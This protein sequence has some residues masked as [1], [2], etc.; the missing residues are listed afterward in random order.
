MRTVYVA[1]TTPPVVALIGPSTLTNECHGAFV[2][3]GATASDVCAG[4]LSV[5]TNSTINSSTVGSYTITYTATDPSG[6]SATTTRT[7]YVSDTTPPVSP[8][9]GANPSP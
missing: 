9:F 1:D 7:V 4:T 5:V 6:N 8:S 3:P 2:D